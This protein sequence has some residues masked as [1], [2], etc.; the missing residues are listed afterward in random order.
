MAKHVVKEL[1]A[2]GEPLVGQGL[3]EVGRNGGVAVLFQPSP[4]IVFGWQEAKALQNAVDVDVEDIS[5]E[6]GL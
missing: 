2:D 4:E 5:V 6:R 1:S 3:V